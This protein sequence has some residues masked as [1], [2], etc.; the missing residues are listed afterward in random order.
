MCLGH[1]C[2]GCRTPQ[3]PM[4]SEHLLYGTPPP[5]VQSTTHCLLRP[6]VPSTELLRVTAVESLP[7]WP[8]VLETLS[9]QLTVYQPGPGAPLDLSTQGQG[10]TPMPHK[11]C[12]TMTQTMRIWT[13]GEDIWY[14]GPQLWRPWPAICTS[15]SYS[16]DQGVATLTSGAASFGWPYDCHLTVLPNAGGELAPSITLKYQIY[17]ALKCGTHNFT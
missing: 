2:W 11:H 3:P 17:S 15:T 14:W 16:A 12:N 7:T 8:Q 5:G 13:T 6:P 10:H 4:W 1:I 9:V